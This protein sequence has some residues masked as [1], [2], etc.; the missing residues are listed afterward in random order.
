MVRGETQWLGAPL[1]FVVHSLLILAAIRATRAISSVQHPTRTLPVSIAFPVQTRSGQHGVDGGASGSPLP[2]PNF[3]PPPINSDP[4][5]IPVMPGPLFTGSGLLH[6]VMTSEGGARL[7]DQPGGDPTTS[8]PVVLSMAPPRYPT[9]EM[10]RP[11]GAIDSVVVEYVVELSGRVEE[12]QITVTAATAASFARSVRKALVGA[13]FQPAA[14][15]GR[16]VPSLVRQLFRFV[17][18]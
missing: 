6:S 4:A 3:L 2:A 8:G 18:Q 17:R 9:E 14:Q 1:S 10:M 11:A 12:S 7:P 15:A 5:P 16:A 13:R